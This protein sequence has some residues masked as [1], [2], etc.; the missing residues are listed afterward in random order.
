M[1]N[2]NSYKIYLNILIVLIMT[3]GST[4]NPIP[5]GQ[6][7]LLLVSFSVLCPKF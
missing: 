6:E 7:N 3:F 2:Q 1:K 5:A 4:I